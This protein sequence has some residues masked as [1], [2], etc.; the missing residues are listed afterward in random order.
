MIYEFLGILKLLVLTFGLLSRFNYE[1][2]FST[3]CDEDSL[4]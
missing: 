4:L 1:H 2:K 3:F